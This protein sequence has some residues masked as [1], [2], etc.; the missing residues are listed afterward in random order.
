VR[1]WVGDTGLV[2]AGSHK[3]RT[4]AALRAK[5]AALTANATPNPT[6]TAS[7][8]A[9]GATRIWAV[10]A[11]VQMPLLAAISSSSSTTEGSSDCAAGE[12]NT[13]PDDSL[14]ATA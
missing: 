12:K 10:T 11:A 8:A 3:P 4:T 2:R 14:N 1:E 5:L 9:T 7:R 6:L 13:C